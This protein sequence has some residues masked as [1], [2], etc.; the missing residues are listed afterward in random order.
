MSSIAN[1]SFNGLVELEEGVS[2]FGHPEITL[3]L[4]DE[5][6]EQGPIASLTLREGPTVDG[7]KLYQVH[8]DSDEDL[9]EDK[10]TLMPLEPR[11]LMGMLAY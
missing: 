7:I 11:A 10:W 5:K 6:L 4:F 3:H 1:H 9:D 8:E 2:P